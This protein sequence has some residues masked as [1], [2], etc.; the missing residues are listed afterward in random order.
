M[1]TL[2]KIAAYQ[3]KLANL[4]NILQGCSKDLCVASFF[5]FYQNVKNEIALIGGLKL[6]SNFAGAQFSGTSKSTSF[7][8]INI[9]SVY[10]YVT[11]E[12]VRGGGG[13][14]AQQSYKIVYLFF[15][16]SYFPSILTG[17]FEGLL[18]VKQDH[19]T[20]HCIHCYLQQTI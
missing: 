1:S 13:Y 9:S 14:R 20:F 8:N 6:R 19:C 18:Q 7:G 15:N 5:L 10:L 11:P 2:Y 16:M 12:N 4:L 3:S 17:L